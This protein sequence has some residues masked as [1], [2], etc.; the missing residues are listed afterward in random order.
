[1]NER[2][3]SRA[4]SNVRIAAVRRWIH[5]GG[6]NS[7][8]VAEAVARRIIERGDLRDVHDEPNHRFPPQ[9]RRKTLH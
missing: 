4:L 5:E 9:R 2:S 7:P 1:M 8:A 3:S 6:H